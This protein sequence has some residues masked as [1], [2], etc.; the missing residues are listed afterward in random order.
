[1]RFFSLIIFLVVSITQ[2]CE[3]PSNDDPSEKIKQVESGLLP[4]IVIAGDSSST[5]DLYERMEFY[6]VPGLSLAVIE[7]GQLAW[8]KGYGYLS[9]AKKVA[10]D[11]TTLFQAASIS[12]PVAALA[13]LKLAEEGKVSLDADVNTYLHDDWRIASNRF[14]QDH[15][16]SLRNLLTHTGGLTVHGFPGYADGD[17]LPSLVEI[18]QGIPPANTALIEVD[19]LPGA[20]WRYSGGGY[21]VMQ[22]VIEDRTGLPFEKYLEEAVLMPLNMRNS[23]YEQPLPLSRH[24]QASTGHRNDGTPVKGNWH[25]YPEKAAA[26]LWTTP[27]DLAHY[28]TGVMKMYRGEEGP[29]SPSSTREMLRKHLGD[30]GLGPALQM[31]EDSLYFGHG[32]A[33]EGYR[34]RFV[35]LPETGQGAVVMTN[36]D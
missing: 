27:T 16:V 23:T 33:N 20:H 14:T 11:T 7:G 36:S 10:I 30:W 2:S 35:A 13:A 24:P 12:K 1:M 9:Q 32:G 31:V 22:K 4:P 5:F 19:T 3:K 18:L 17:T 26:G 28:I 25:T 6:K 29:I 34:A 15:P 21:T 8:A